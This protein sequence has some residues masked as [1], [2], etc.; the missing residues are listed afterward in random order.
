MTRNR[1]S[2]VYKNQSTDGGRNNIRKG[3]D[4]R[5]ADLRY[6]IFRGRAGV[7]AMSGAVMWPVEV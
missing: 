2:R 7:R 4:V 3:A 6:D 5:G 1:F